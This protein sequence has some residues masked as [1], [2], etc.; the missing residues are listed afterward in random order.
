MINKAGKKL[1]KIKLRFYHVIIL[2]IFILIFILGWTFIE[3][4]AKQID[5][6]KD[7]LSV[8]ESNNVKVK[9]NSYQINPLSEIYI[10]RNYSEIISLAEKNKLPLNNS[11]STNYLV[12]MSYF[13]KR[14]YVKASQYLKLVVNNDSLIK[15]QLYYYLGTSY[16]FMGHADQSLN[17]F[18]LLRENYPK[19]NYLIK[20]IEMEAKTFIT[21]KKYNLLISTYFPLIDKSEDKIKDRLLYFIGSAY[22]LLGKKDQAFDYYLKVVNLYSQTYT[23]K[24]LERMR[25]INPNYEKKLNHVKRIL[26]AQYYY[27]SANR[28]LD[29]DKYKKIISLLA[30]ITQL[31]DDLQE[32]DRL[33]LLGRAYI[34]I[35]NYNLAKNTFQKIFSKFKPNSIYYQK[36]E[37]WYAKYFER[38]DTKKALIIYKN[39]INSTNHPF[40]KEVCNDL[41]N[42]I[43]MKEPE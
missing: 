26:L 5:T 31:K 12:G 8:L 16:H 33:F 17:Y 20:L 42:L 29:T 38:F 34:K 27:K 35:G 30:S 21:Q 25:L 40:M 2:I 11:F 32:F 10:K 3:I 9:V 23:R 4:N 15:E 43:D 7:F 1:K 19:S 39:I 41:L 14:Q 36:G 24:A 22:E 6:P 28:R 37:Y 18:K 13:R